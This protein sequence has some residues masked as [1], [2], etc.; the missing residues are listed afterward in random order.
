MVALKDKLPHITINDLT[1]ADSED[2]TKD[3]LLVQVTSQNSQIAQLIDSG[4]E[5]KILFIKENSS[6]N[7]SSAVVRVGCKIRDAIRLNRNRIFIGV[8][9]CRVFD[10][11]FIKCCNN[12]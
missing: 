8:N 3:T 2:I 7:K 1:K 4:E 12:C 9:S 11:F 10:R 5:F 6:T